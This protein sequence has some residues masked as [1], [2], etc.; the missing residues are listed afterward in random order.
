MHT[1]TQYINE[2]I[3]ANVLAW[4]VYCPGS[5][6]NS[7]IQH[8]NT[9]CDPKIRVI[10][11]VQ[12]PRNNLLGQV[13]MTFSMA[14]CPDHLYCSLVPNSSIHNNSE[15]LW[16]AKLST[17]VNIAVLPGC[18]HGSLWGLTQVALE[19][20]LQF[21]AVQRCFHSWMNSWSLERL[22]PRSFH[23]KSLQFLSPK[24]ACH[25][26]SKPSSVLAIFWHSH[27]CAQ[28]ICPPGWGS[29][30]RV[31]CPPHTVTNSPVC[32]GLRKLVSLF[33]SASVNTCIFLNRDYIRFWFH[34]C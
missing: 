22:Q 7:S 34:I 1:G 14:A 4:L 19:L 25:M 32:F 17:E 6:V 13:R 8:H 2:L 12:K 10:K 26:M 33:K 16:R 3:L 29:K 24:A 18:K 27:G 31:Y 28:Q 9:R 15:L 5:N 11:K 21:L 20:K 23:L 30:S